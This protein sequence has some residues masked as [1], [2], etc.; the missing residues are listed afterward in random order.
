MSESRAIA[1][2]EQL[3]SLLPRGLAWLRAPGSIMAKL[4]EGIADE[5]GRFDA[6]AFRLLDEADPGT[7]LE[8]L[9]D[10]ER[11]AGLP[12][13]CLPV[14]GS[15]SERQRRV[16]RKIAGIGGQSRAYFIELAAV[17]GVEIAIEEFAPLRAGFRA[18]AAAY[19]QDW[20]FAWRVRVLAFSEASG[21]VVRSERFRAG[22][23]RAGDRLRSFSV[24]EL[25]CTIRRAAPAHTKVLFAYP[26]EPE[27]IMW[28]DFLSDYGEY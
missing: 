15:I 23:G 21:L 18:G 3:A 19:G 17:L 24:Q 10:W 27:A 13:N 5:F 6:R 28:F 25:E 20:Q 26:N 4:V 7:A 16:T 1:Y 22:V 9:S 14:T 12:D 8:L 2:R 11:V